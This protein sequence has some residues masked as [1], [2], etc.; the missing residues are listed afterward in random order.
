MEAAVPEPSADVDDTCGSA[1]GHRVKVAVV[2][3]SQEEGG[4]TGVG[5]LGRREVKKEEKQFLFPVL[6]E[7][8]SLFFVDH[9]SD[10]VDNLLSDL[11]H[12]DH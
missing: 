2:P 6:F 11:L 8:Q 3:A 10:V 7:Q 4:I 9:D 5:K 12:V 1:V